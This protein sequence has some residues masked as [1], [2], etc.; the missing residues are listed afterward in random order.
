MANA[1]PKGW[2]GQSLR[3]NSR[4][5]I[6]IVWQ[7]QFESLTT[8]VGHSCEVCISSS[9]MLTT[10]NSVSPLWLSL[11]RP[12]TTHP[13]TPPAHPPT[14]QPTNHPHTHKPTY[15]HTHTCAVVSS[16]VCQPASSR[17]RTHSARLVMEVGSC[18]K[19]ERAGVFESVRGSEVCLWGGCVCCR[20]G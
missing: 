4:N 10:N 17:G 6:N 19:C 3:A 16:C 8:E 12:P 2:N 11:Y 13:H 20:A 5:D 15:T 18:E 1:S 14:H 7:R 9:S